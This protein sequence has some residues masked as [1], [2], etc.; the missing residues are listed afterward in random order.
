MKMDDLLINLQLQMRIRQ[1]PGVS[2]RV[3][4]NGKKLF[5]CELGVSNLSSKELLESWHLYRVGSLTKPITAYAVLRL[6]ELGELALSNSICSYIPELKTHPQLQSVTVSDLLSHTSGL[7]RG[8]Y[9]AQALSDDEN[10]I[11]IC[12]SQLLFSPGTRFKYSN[13]GYYLLGKVVESITEYTPEVYIAKVVFHPLGMNQS[14]IPTNKN[15]LES[16]LA[17]GYWSGWRFGSADLSE[18]AMP[19]DH[20]ALPNCAAG[21][22]SNADDYLKWLV[23]LTIKDKT[24]DHVEV[25]VVQQLLKTRYKIGRNIFSSYGMFVEIINGVEF[26][27]FAGL[28]SGFSSFFFIIPDLRLT[29]IALANQGTCSDELREMLHLVC[30]A[31]VLNKRLPH[32]GRRAASLNVLAKNVKGDSIQ[33]ESTKGVTTGL[34]KDG[35]LIELY[36]YSEK[37]YFQING[38]YRRHMLRIGGVG[39]ENLMISLGDQIYYKKHN[40]LRREK[41]VHEL[42]SQLSGIY[43]YPA[44]GKL[45]IIFRAGQIYLSY[46][47]MY[48]ILLKQFSELVFKQQSGPFRYEAVKFIRDAD[49]AKIE[50]FVLDGMKFERYGLND[51]DISCESNNRHF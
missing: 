33:L 40:K 22:I 4:Q 16:K 28:R 9:H 15:K 43:N 41:E 27:F 50:S 32:F 51:A 36:P 45:E 23:K 13:W 6:A 42:L 18:Q 19:C 12:S 17:S 1:I 2:I 24:K 5:G 47:A 39:N 3:A 37:V 25:G 31:N 14:S 46:G 48:E 21:M 38:S 10:L 7:A 49:T 44:F 26:Y 29:G 30:Q 20:G 8:P 35:S 11:Q 34:R